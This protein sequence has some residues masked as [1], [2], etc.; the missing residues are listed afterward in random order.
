MTCLDNFNLPPGLA[1]SGIPGNSRKEVAV[2]WAME[3]A[4]ELVGETL[5]NLCGVSI[6]LQDA[7]DDGPEEAQHDICNVQ[8]RLEEAQVKLDTALNILGRILE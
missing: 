2:G 8:D 1:P 6:S 7:F 4:Q 5:D 3:K